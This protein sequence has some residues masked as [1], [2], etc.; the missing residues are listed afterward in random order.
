[1]AN[2]KYLYEYTDE[3]TIEELKIHGALSVRTANVLIRAGKKR[4]IGDIKNLKP[5]EIMRI[6]NVGRHTIDEIVA[7][8]R[9]YKHRNY[10]VQEQKR[11]IS[12]DDLLAYC[13]KCADTMQ[14]LA[15]KI[16]ADI[17][18]GESE[19]SALGG[20]AYFLQEARLYRFDIPNIIE[21]FIKESENGT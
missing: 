12:A 3:T 21:C 6:R 17:G 19:I 20:C 8:Q 1:M 4:N 7:F 14:D 9:I 2:L 10:K 13:H 15:D 5:E 11:L 16:L 18:K